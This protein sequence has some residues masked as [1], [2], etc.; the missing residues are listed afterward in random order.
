M[1]HEALR[2]RWES[3]K[4]FDVTG[5]EASYDFGHP[6]AGDLLKDLKLAAN[7]TNVTDK[8]G[9]STAVVTSNSGGYQAYPIA[10]RMFFVTVSAKFLA[11][12]RGTPAVV[13]PDG[14]RTARHDPRRRARPGRDVPAPVGFFYRKLWVY[15]WSFTALI[16]M[17]GLLPAG[18]PRNCKHR[19]TSSQ[20]LIAAKSSECEKY[21]A[22]ENCVPLIGSLIRYRL[23]AGSDRRPG[24]DSYAGQSFAGLC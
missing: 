8:R 6:F 21:D 20:S 15:A 11:Q 14:H 18:T 10:P 23:R 3:A 13:I 5:L 24:G 22:L 2:I 1:G 19:F 12:R 17:V 16:V 7:I 4:P 9:V